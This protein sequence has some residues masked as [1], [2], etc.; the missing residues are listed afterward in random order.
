V[1]QPE[2]SAEVEYECQFTALRVARSLDRPSN[3]LMVITA[4]RVLTDGTTRCDPTP[5]KFQ[6][7]DLVIDRPRDD[8]PPFNYILKPREPL[9]AI[10]KFVG[11]S[12]AFVEL[13]LR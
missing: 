12:E 6:F 2:I 4:D 8:G 5:V 13:G 11:A 7:Y 9:M 1:E 3:T 10:G